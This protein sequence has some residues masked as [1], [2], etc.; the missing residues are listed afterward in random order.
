MTPCS[1][2][3]LFLINYLSVLVLKPPRVSTERPVPK[4]LAVLSQIL[5]IFE[6]TTTRV[7]IARPRV[8]CQF[9]LSQLSFLLHIIH[10]WTRLV[11]G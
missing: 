3:S 6:L 2:L 9:C 1:F 5:K 7:G 4:V 11:S 10:L 8:G